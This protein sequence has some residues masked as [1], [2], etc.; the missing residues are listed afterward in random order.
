MS[1]NG[2][3]ALEHVDRSSAPPLVEPLES[4]RDGAPRVTIISETLAR[5]IWPG[6]SAIGRSFFQQES[7]TEERE[8]QVVGVARD[9]KYRYISSPPSPF[10][11][12][13]MA[14][15]PTSNLEFYIRH[16]P[17]ARVTADIRTAMTQVEPNVPIVMLQSF[18]DAVALGL[19]PQKFAALIAGSV[20]TVRW[21]YSFSPPHWISFR[22]L[23]RAAEWLLPQAT[24]R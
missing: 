15:V 9:A 6:Q 2:G 17:G 3:L 21:P 18:D 20:G 23:R 4:D 16:A 12:V 13:A 5:Q 24:E 10:I 22:S 7:D 1:T 8:F 19:L 11:Y 14:Q